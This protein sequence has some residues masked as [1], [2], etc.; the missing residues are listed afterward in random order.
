MASDFGG[1]HAENDNLKS[2]NS[3]D[4]EMDFFG[5]HFFLEEVK[6]VDFFGHF[7]GG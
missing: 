6:G 4:L 2:V 7:V 3:V 5:G 1:G